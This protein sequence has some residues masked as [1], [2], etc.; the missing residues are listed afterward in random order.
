M[1]DSELSVLRRTSIGAWIVIAVLSLLLVATAVIAHLGWTLG[2]ANVPASG[3]VAMGFGV[4]FSL[5]V[6]IGLMTLL[7]YSSRA[8]Y[9]GPAVLIEERRTDSHDFQ[10]TSQEEGS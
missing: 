4:I 6:G 8:G 7:F 2:D 9:D 3:Y 10:R 5:I 1:K